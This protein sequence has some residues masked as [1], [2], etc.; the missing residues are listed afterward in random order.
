[1]HSNAALLHAAPRRGAAATHAALLHRNAALLQRTRRCRTATPRC[2][3]AT[4]RCCNARGVAATQRR[5]CCIDGLFAMGFGCTDIHS[6]SDFTCDFTAAVKLFHRD[7]TAAKLFTWISSQYF[8]IPPRFPHD[9]TINYWLNRGVIAAEFLA[10]QRESGE[11]Q[12]R[13]GPTK[14]KHFAAVESRWNRGG[15]SSHG[16]GQFCPRYR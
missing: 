15:I 1:M 3:I 12:V 13:I 7:S 11:S 5:P 2:C 10:S 14:F 9:F 16:I 8:Y 4:R 6:V